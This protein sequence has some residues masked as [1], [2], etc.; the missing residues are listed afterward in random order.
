MFG[1]GAVFGIF[2]GFAVLALVFTLLFVRKTT[3]R[4]LEELELADG[5]G[6]EATKGA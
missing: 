5:A 1:A 4:S 2:A 3:N 6:P